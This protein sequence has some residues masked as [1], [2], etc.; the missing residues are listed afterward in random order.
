MRTLSFLPAL[1]LL[2]ATGLAGCNI[3]GGPT[4]CTQI[5][6]EDGLTVTLI[7]APTGPFQLSAEVSGEIVG[8]VE[9]PAGS[10]CGSM[11]I[12][13][14]SSDDVTLILT[15]GEDVRRFDVR[16]TYT[17]IQP[18]GPSCPPVCRVGSVTIQL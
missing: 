8:T 15:Q 14:V 6:C 7:G 13:G 18:N 12:P 11:V 2:A 4:F 3:L 16:P 17:T 9:C 10:S 5:G 1:L